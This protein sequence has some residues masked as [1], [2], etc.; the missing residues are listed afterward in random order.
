MTAALLLFVLTI[1]E[2]KLF[3]KLS[4]NAGFKNAR[5]LMLP[6]HKYRSTEDVAMTDIVRVAT[7]GHKLFRSDHEYKN[8]KFSRLNVEGHA[9]IVDTRFEDCTFHNVSFADVM[10]RGCVFK[11]CKFLE[12]I[13]AGSRFIS[14]YIGNTTTRHV[15]FS[16]CSLRNTRLDSWVNTDL[17][18]RGTIIE[19]CVLKNFGIKDITH[20]SASLITSCSG[21]HY[22]Q[23]NFDMMG[24]SGR[25]LTML[26]EGGVRMFF[27]GCFAGSEDSLRHLILVEPSCKNVRETRTLAMET[28]LKIG[29]ATDPLR[30]NFKPS[31][32]NQ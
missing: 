6:R 17:K 23:V 29:A 24:Q 12:C 25:T 21:L 1:K 11:N 13:F 28:L 22:A 26:T 20:F 15:T 4:A 14:C 16:S 18:I 2:M 5:R 32:P 30:P 9:D 19:G 27:C 7:K 8:C 3:I 31:Q 10:C